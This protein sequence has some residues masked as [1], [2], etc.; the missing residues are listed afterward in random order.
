MN[1]AY[2]QELRSSAITLNGRSVCIVDDDKLYCGHLA[3]LLKQEHIRT[4]EAGDSAT[5]VQ[6]LEKEMPDCILLDYNLHAENGFRLHEQLK[7][8]FP[9][10]APV[11]MLSADESQ[12]TAIKAFRMG[13]YDFLPKR[14]LRLE[15]MTSVIRKTIVRHESEVARFAEVSAL[16]K[17]AMFDDLTGMYCRAELDTKLAHVATSAIK[18]RR[19]FAIFSICLADYDAIGTNFG[20]ANADE[21]LRSFAGKIR[22]TIRSDDFCGRFDEDSF[23]YVMDRNVTE[24]NILEC[25]RRLMEKLTFSYHLKSV[26]LQISPLIGVAVSSE[27]ADLAG[28]MQSLAVEQGHQ[29]DALRAQSNPNDWSALPETLADTGSGVTEARERRKSLRMRTLK[30]AFIAIEE[31][32]SKISC[33]IRNI[34]D[35]GARIRL[36]QPLALPEN[37]LLQISGSG[38]LRPVRKCWHINNEVGIEFSD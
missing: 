5:L 26:E 38:P 17:K 11:I 27:H 34:S 7:L 8:R 19:D 22:S 23:R 15:E 24:D 25:Q 31:W 33:T 9:D 30:P 3:S 10:L 2:D 21:V 29:R 36:D 20:I 14:N 12:R 1:V 18:F 13:F 4:M 32:S 35:G 28:M 16:R 37:F 6:V